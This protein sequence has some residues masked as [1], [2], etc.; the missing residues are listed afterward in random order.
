MRSLRFANY[1]IVFSYV[2]FTKII[3]IHEIV[4]IKNKENA[5]NINTGILGKITKKWLKWILQK[6]KDTGTWIFIPKTG[7]LDLVDKSSKPCIIDTV[8]RDRQTHVYR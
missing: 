8:V 6:R 1:I 3:Q 2:N 5:M 4:Y 7:S